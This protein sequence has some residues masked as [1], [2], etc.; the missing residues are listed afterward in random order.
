M[1]YPTLRDGP[2]GLLRV[3]LGGISATYEVS[4]VTLDNYLSV[5][6]RGV[7]A[8]QAAVAIAR[9]QCR[10]RTMQEAAKQASAKRPPHYRKYRKFPL[11]CMRC[12]HSAGPPQMAAQTGSANCANPRCVPPGD[13]TLQRDQRK[14]VSGKCGKCG[15]SP[16]GRSPQ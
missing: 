16:A 5:T 10:C 3:R 15:N 1:V 4:E 8:N 14:T 7:G 9:E 11:G 6:Y 12:L 13:A 2:A